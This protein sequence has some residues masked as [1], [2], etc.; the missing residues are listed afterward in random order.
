MGRTIFS[1]MRAVILLRSFGIKLRR[2]LAWD[3]AVIV[4]DRRYHSRM[5][6]RMKYPV[7]HLPIPTEGTLLTPEQR[8]AALRAALAHIEKYGLPVPGTYPRMRIVEAPNK[9]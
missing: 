7:D 4:I 2:T 5:A 6:K 8:E 3:D 9:R 1:T